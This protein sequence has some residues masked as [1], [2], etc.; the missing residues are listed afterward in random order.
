MHPEEYTKNHIQSIIRTIQRTFNEIV[1]LDL[2]DEEFEERDELV[3]S[4]CLTLDLAL[5]RTL[6]LT[7][8]EIDLVLKALNSMATERT[9]DLHDKILEQW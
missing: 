6:I 2:S 3:M 9:D 1:E 7:N 8:E 4:C 5:D